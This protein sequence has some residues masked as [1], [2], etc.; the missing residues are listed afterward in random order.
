MLIL[1][2][3]MAVLHHT[4]PALSNKSLYLSHREKKTKSEEREVVNMAV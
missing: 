1:L 3:E 2:L 4:P